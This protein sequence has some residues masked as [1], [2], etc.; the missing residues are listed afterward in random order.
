MNPSEMSE[1]EKLKNTVLRAQCCLLVVVGESISGMWGR[2]RHT[3]VGW[4]GAG[5]VG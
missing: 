3:G 2:D 5:Y 4:K 1:G